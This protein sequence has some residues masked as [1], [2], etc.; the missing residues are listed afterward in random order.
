RGRARATRLLSLVAAALVAASCA[1]VAPSGS[2]SPAATLTPSAAATPTLAPVPSSAPVPTAS[3]HATPAATPPPTPQPTP[4][5]PPAGDETLAAV[6]TAPRP[7]N[8]RSADGPRVFARGDDLSV[9]FE[10]INASA[11]PVAVPRTLASDRPA[12]WYGVIQAWIEPLGA[13]VNLDTCLPDAARKGGWYATGGTPMALGGSATPLDPGV[14]PTQRFGMS[15]FQTACLPAGPYRFHLE[16]KRFDAGPDDVIA[17]LALN[18]ELRDATGW[19]V[20]LPSPG[21]VDSQ[22]ALTL[23]GDAKRMTSAI[24]LRGLPAGSEVTVTVRAGGC[25]REGAVIVPARTLTATADGTLTDRSAIQLTSS[26]RQAIAAGGIPGLRLTQG[27]RRSCTVYSAM[28]LSFPANRA[29]TTWGGG[30]LRVE[31]AEGIVLTASS[32]TLQGP[33]AH[34]ADG[35]IDNM[36]NS[37]GYA[38][39][40]VELDLGRNTRLTGVKLLPSQLPNVADTLHRIYGRVDGSRTEVLLAELKG[41]TQDNTW[42][43]ATFA[44]MQRIRYIRVATVTSPSWIAWREIRLQGPDVAPPSVMP[45]GMQD[46]AADLGAHGDRCYANGWATD[47]DD[48][49]RSVT[50]RILVDGKQ[51]WSG[52]AS[53]SRPDVAAAGFGNGRSG[54]WVRL[55]GLLTLGV[56][57]EIR[58]QALDAETG[59]WVDL[60]GTPKTLRCN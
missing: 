23:S 27:T 58:V 20:G 33:V 24:T 60:N 41:T 57:H 29:P 32:Q 18:V 53:D 22:A 7:Q 49:S 35:A 39:A 46:G 38:P 55:D 45:Q 36:W 17:H 12:S 4:Q 8:L 51:V 13:R 2:P 16:Y 42:I 34:A 54:Y 52:P 28:P 25:D 30:L 6:Y 21:G 43:E 44:K 37:G 11:V 40:W 3:P 48:S 59:R 1:A 19:T 31:T 9:L 5:V 56:S 14:G 47:P 26:A 10:I 15:A 50:V